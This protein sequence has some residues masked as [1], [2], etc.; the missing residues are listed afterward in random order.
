LA[1]EQQI[2]TTAVE[3]RRVMPGHG[4]GYAERMF[5]VVTRISARMFEGFRR[6]AR[7]QASVERPRW[8]LLR[9]A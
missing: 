2:A 5:I 4:G 8:P 1:S 9:K 6:P 7:P 3:A